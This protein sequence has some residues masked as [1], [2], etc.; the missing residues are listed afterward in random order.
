MKQSDESVAGR[1]A[2]FINTNR[3][4]EG[5]GEGGEMVPASLVVAS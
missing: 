2:A 1:L 3:D 4:E 5:G